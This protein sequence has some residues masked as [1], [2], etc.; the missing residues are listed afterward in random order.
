MRYPETK[1]PRAISPGMLIA[2]L[3]IHGILLISL[4]VLYASS[5]ERPE[6]K[7]VNVSRVKLVEHPRPEDIE[8]KL[9]TE[10]F[11]QVEEPEPAPLR[12]A[13]LEKTDIRPKTQALTSKLL[14]SRSEKKIQI[15]KYKRKAQKIEAKKKTAEDQIDRNPEPQKSKSPD[16]VIEKRLAEIRKQLKKKH[17]ENSREISTHSSHTEGD[18]GQSVGGNAEPTVEDPQLVMWLEQVK[19]RINENWSILP[20]TTEFDKVAVIGVK[21]ARDGSLLVASVDSSSGDELFDRSAIRAVHQASPFPPVPPQAVERI[22]VAGGLALRFTPG[23][24][25]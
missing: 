2:S 8:K 13:K 11:S 16:E 20:H 6:S 4:V 15:K 5:H 1:L 9:K 23:G 17:E 21:M 3:I 19:Q 24:L 18:R 14:S 10:T 22:R 25:Q 12:I 7:Y